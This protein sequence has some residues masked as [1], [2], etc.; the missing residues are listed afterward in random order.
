M[1]PAGEQ[2]LK[3]RKAM[4]VAAAL[5]VFASSFAAATSTQPVQ[6]FATVLLI[7]LAG[8]A[9]IGGLIHLATRNRR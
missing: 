2:G 7:A 8:I 4:A 1:S 6:S 5:A 3:L 9:V